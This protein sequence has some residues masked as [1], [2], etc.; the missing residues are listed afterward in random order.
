[1]RGFENRASFFVQTDS[2]VKNPNKIKLFFIRL[3]ACYW[4]A[5]RENINLL[6]SN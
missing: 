5:A 4:H 2:T 1:M 3:A 6:L